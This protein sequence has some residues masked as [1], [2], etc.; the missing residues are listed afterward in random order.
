MDLGFIFSSPP[1]EGSVFLIAPPRRPPRRRPRP[2]PPLFWGS[3]I[4]Q[5]RTRF[6][7]V[8][9]LNTP[10]HKTRAFFF[11]SRNIILGSQRYFC[12]ET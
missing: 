9:R 2:P 12:P 10:F 6:W 5:E 1:G 11:S 4:K 7:E 3:I 8:V